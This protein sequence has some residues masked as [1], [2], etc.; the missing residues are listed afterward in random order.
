MLISLKMIYLIN[1]SLYRLFSSGVIHLI[2]PTNIYYQ[3]ALPCVAL[4]VVI[5]FR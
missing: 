2:C 5:F 4:Q 3:E 1:E